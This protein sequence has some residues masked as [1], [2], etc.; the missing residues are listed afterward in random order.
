[1]LCLGGEVD[2]NRHGIRRVIG[3]DRG[4]GRA[5]EDVDP[6]SPEE[7]ALG[8]GDKGVTG[9]DDDV[10]LATGEEAE[11][12]T[13]HGVH[14]AHLQDGVGA[15][16]IHGIGHRRVDRVTARRRTGHDEVNAGDLGRGDAHDSGGRVGVAAA[17]HVAAGALHRQHAL[18]QAHAGGGFDLE[19]GQAVLLGLCETPNLIVGELN[20]ILD[21]LR[22]LLDEPGFL[23]VT[24]NEVT[25]PVVELL[26]IVPDRFFAAFVDV[27]QH[28][29]N[30][31]AGLAI[32]LLR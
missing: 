27:R 4:F 24:E 13:G 18:P 16:Q 28:G 8:L 31:I 9:P 1:M 7:K 21:L 11:S 19:F 32:L 22:D 10:G 3:D 30:H 14:A 29:F 6:D 26:G 12:H 23:F 5:G 20:V 25:G 17:G 15:G 2:G